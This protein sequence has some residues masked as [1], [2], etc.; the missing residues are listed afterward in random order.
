ML[1]K[2]AVI[3]RIVTD[4]TLKLQLVRGIQSTVV[5]RWREYENERYYEPGEDVLNRT[6]HG[7]TYDYRRSKRRF[8]EA[9]N[10]AFQ[11]RH[12][13]AHAKSK[14]QNYELLPYRSDFV[15]IGGGL[16]GSAAAFWIKQW[17]RDEDLS[18][19]VI[20]DPDRFANTRSI[21]SCGEVTQ[22]FDQPELVEMA[23]FSA[24]FMR[25][26]GDH[27]RV[28]DSEKP[29]ISFYPCGF[30]HLAMTEE[31]ADRLKESWKMQIS[32]G[33]KVAFYNKN[34]AEQKFLFMNFD[35]VVAATYGLE[36][37]GFF[38]P[39]Q[40]LGALR[41]KNITLG[42]D[43]HQGRV[44]DFVYR[45]LD[46]YNPPQGLTD[47]ADDLMHKRKMMRSIVVQPKM[48]G[49][50][51]RPISFY[52]CV[53]AAGPWAGQVAEMAGIGKGE[54]ALAVPIPIV[55]RKRQ[56]FV[57]HAPDVPALEMPALKD[58]SGVF[59]RP[60]EPGYS[61]ICG[62]KPSREEDALTDHS[63]LTVDYDY[64][65]KNVWPVLCHRVPTFKNATVM[66][67]WACHEDV[68]TFDDAPIIG[69]HLQ[70]KNFFTMAG[71]ANYGAQMGIAAGKL[72]SEKAMEYAYMTTNVRKFDMRRLIMGKK[73]TEGNKL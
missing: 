9:R 66:N 30:M 12:P 36:N 26:A 14:I 20:E 55:A 11:R 70:F 1:A 60:F 44:D 22:Q 64:F 57:V 32:K 3:Q 37:E 61:F 8:R 69:E 18:V 42:V 45:Q 33:A 16:S 40:L 38:D 7:L 73:E 65:Y 31:D 59:C 21:L 13:I 24:E 63:D 35:G 28:L 17:F 49:A 41:E 2:N 29:N 52:Q 68:N 6:W 46:L 39:V 19:S 58:P 51:S 56:Y 43:Y 53:N 25:H 71:F 5:N 15:I 23:M 34:E 62:R 50:S 72:Y 27:L 67:A 48:T 47:E 4:S 10:D 54:G